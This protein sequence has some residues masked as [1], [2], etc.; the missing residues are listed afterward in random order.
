MPEVAVSAPGTPTWIDVSTKDVDGAVAFYEGVFGWQTVDPGP[1]AGGYRLFKKNGKDVAGIGPTQDP[2]QPPAWSVYIATE[3]ADATA[4]KVKQAGGNVIAPPFDVLKSGRMAV[5]QDPTGAF[6]S[7]W[8]ANE[9]KG[10]E[11][12]DE[13]GTLAWAELNT[14]GVDNAKGFYKQ[15]FGWGDKPA[16]LH[17]VAAQREEHCRRH[18]DRTER[19]QPAVAGAPALARL[20]RFG[21]RRRH[22]QEGQGPRW[23][24][25]HGAGGLPGRQVQR[26][27]RPDGRCVRHPEDEPKLV[28]QEH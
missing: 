22:H 8:Q 17:R 11:L 5:F 24:G 14:R 12:M 21:R 19:D 16:A 3:N 18:G 4:E 7:V 2:N 15:V 1:D 6:I 13:P 25:E 23:Q 27:H 9:M 28:K 20:H 26:H 10:S